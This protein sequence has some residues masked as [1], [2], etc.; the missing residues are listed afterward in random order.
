MQTLHHMEA[1]ML[2]DVLSKSSLPAILVAC[3]CDQHPAHREVDP[4]V[5]EHK[6]KQFLPDVNVFQTSQASP[7]TQKSC[8][9]VITRAVIASKRREYALFYLAMLR[10]RSVCVRPVTDMRNECSASIRAPH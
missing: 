3:K 7:E 2:L 1:D 5:V 4:A 10:H 8:L 6:A 9:S